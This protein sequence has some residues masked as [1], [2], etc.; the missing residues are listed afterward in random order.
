[1]SPPI[2]SESSLIRRSIID[3]ARAIIAG[4]EGRGVTPYAGRRR[5]QLTVREHE[6]FGLGEP[7]E[8]IRRLLSK[9]DRHLITC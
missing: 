2:L 8:S 3:V 1:M 9:S 4:S 7:G 5:W 6:F